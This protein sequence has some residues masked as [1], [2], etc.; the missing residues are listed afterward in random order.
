[1]I[2]I[3]IDVSVCVSLS[4]FLS[5]VPPAVYQDWDV[6]LAFTDDYDA[7]DNAN[8]TQ[9][10]LAAD[11]AAQAVDSGSTLRSGLSF[12]LSLSLSLGLLGL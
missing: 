12:F 11:L 8:F 10:V 6:K 7:L 1:M 4:L 3:D 2:Y 9:S 5:F